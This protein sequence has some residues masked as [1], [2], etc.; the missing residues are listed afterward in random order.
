[1]KNFM[2]SEITIFEKVS[3]KKH[4][5]KIL[6]QVHTY[7]IYH[8]Y[9]YHDVHS[10]IDRGKPVLLVIKHEASI[11]ALPLLE[12]KINSKH[13]DAS[14]VYG[15]PGPITNISDD[16]FFNFLY[17][18]LL[19]E[20]SKS[21]KYVS[22]FSRINSHVISNSCLDKIFQKH[23]ST[24][25]I[26]LKD[27][28]VNQ[29]KNFRKK[30]RYDVN[31]LV[32]LGFS[33]NFVPPVKKNLNI[34]YNIYCSAMKTIGASDYYFFDESYFQD[35][36]KIK[37]ADIKLAHVSIGDEVACVGIFFFCNGIAQYHLSA[38]HK[39]YIKYSPTKLMI[40]YVRR[41]ANSKGCS[42]FHL[43]GGIGGKN[44]SLLNFKK[45]FSEKMDNFYVMKEVLNAD[46]YDE[47]SSNSLNSDFFP[48]YRAKNE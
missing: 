25:S 43:G 22:I 39:K 48:K 17:K 6:D 7:D 41:Y 23:G 18:K 32:N 19:S 31:R 12:R 45:G 5:D 37:S 13:A 21:L 26:N 11:I 2:S 28:P 10:R 14:S 47:L 33:C 3:K 42:I 40:D 15:Y 30:L 9:E 24:V 4:W 36:F 44:D 38:N 35:L 20:I 29:F 1:M 46:K 8:T 16:F 34:F 27:N